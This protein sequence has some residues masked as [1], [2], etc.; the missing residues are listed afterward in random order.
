MLYKPLVQNNIRQRAWDI[1]RVN[2][3]E[4]VRVKV[5]HEMWDE[6]WDSVY[7]KVRQIVRIDET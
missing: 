7:L 4:N 1:T 3:Y 5:Q 6:I 2:V